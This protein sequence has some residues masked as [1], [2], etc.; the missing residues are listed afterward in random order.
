M[1]RLKD[2]SATYCFRLEFWKNKTGR[3]HE[4]PLAPG[5][6]SRAVEAAFFDGL[7]KGVFPDYDFH[8]EQAV[9]EPRFVRPGSGSPRVASFEVALPTPDGGGNCLAFERDFFH[10][11]VR[12]VA[13]ELIAAGKV[14]EDGVLLYQL[15]AYL[16]EVEKPRTRGL[17]IELESE[18]PEIPIRPGSR[19]ALGTSEAWDGPRPEDFPV[20]IPR[21]VVEESV[22]EA[23]RAPEREVGGVLLGHLRRDREDGE[24]YL[25]VTALVPAEETEA[26][27]LSVTFT[28][29]TWARA[30]E[31][32]DVRGEGEIFVGWMHSHPFRFCKECP[33]PV[34]KECME[35]VLFY[36]AD[37]EFL[38]E[39]SFARPFMIGLLAAVEPRLQGALGHAPIKLYGWNKGLIEARGFEVIES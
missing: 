33:L 22:E 18:M 10:N 13:K 25:E 4:V 14:V 36:S 35:K 6:F 9:I 23:R 1:P 39:L 12:R 30:R 19:R 31:V 17:S 5:D 34:P 16:D 3:I 26:T 32:I 8:A 21:R 11:L 37:D 24:L 38:M 27:E 7:R 15:A 20:F 28:S 29:A 2:R